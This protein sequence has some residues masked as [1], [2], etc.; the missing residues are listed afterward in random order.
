MLAVYLSPLY[1]LLNGYFLYRILKWLE[2]CGLPLKR[3]WVRTAVI[4]GYL[5]FALSLLMAFFSPEGMVRRALKLISNYWLGVLLYMAIGI[6]T[7]DLLRLVLGRV[8]GIDRKKLYTKKV[9]RAAGGLCAGAIAAVSIFGVVNASVIRVT[10]YEITVEKRAGNL[11]SLNVVLAADLHLGYNIGISRMKK[12]V[13]KINEQDA[14]LVVI[15]GDIFDNEYEAV[16]NPDEMAALLGEIH[17]R[18]GVYAC[19]GNHDIQEPILAGFTFGSDEKKISDIRMD[20]LL[21]KAGIRLLKDEAVLV[22]DSF[23]LYGRPDFERPNR[24]IEKRKTPAEITADLDLTKPVIVID[25][26]PRELQELADAGVDVDLCGHTHD[27][28]LFPANFTVK[29]MWENAYGYLKKGRMHNIV[30][31]GAGLFGPNM[32]VGTKAEIC[33]VNIRFGRKA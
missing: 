16:E 28:Q 20:E 8:K 10:P 30:T 22:E 2:A 23:Y 15:A 3:A 25:H 11:E 6:L 26:E 19:Y 12:I 21:E 24:G 13:E 14:D 17:S 33:T 4:L 5:F 7:A 29:L 1:I 27:G 18:Y 32:R 31:S 9:H